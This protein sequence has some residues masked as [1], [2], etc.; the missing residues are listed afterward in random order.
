MNWQWKLIKKQLKINTVSSLMETRYYLYSFSRTK[1]HTQGDRYFI[2]PLFIF[3][4]LIN[5][6]PESVNHGYEVELA[7]RHENKGAK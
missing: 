5:S 7:L 1:N 4:D 3:P 2:C 6:F